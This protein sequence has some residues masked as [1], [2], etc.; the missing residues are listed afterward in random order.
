MRTVHT[1]TITQAFSDYIGPD[2]DDRVRYLL[3]ELVRHIHD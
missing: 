1:N 3:T 2:T